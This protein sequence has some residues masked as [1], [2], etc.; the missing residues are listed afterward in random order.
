MKLKKYFKNSTENIFSEKIK[1]IMKKVILSVAAMFLLVNMNAQKVFT[2]NGTVS[3]NA[4]SPLEP[5]EG[6]TKKSVGI[7]DLATGKIEVQLLVKSLHFEKALME[8][9]FNENY[10]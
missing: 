10:M 1:L 7:I 3:F 5:I 9:H 8:E 2:K 6:T 4:S